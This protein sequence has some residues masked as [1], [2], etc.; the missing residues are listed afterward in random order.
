MKTFEAK[1]PAFQNQKILA[2]LKGDIERITEELKIDKN[3]KQNFI[4]FI[5]HNFPPIPNANGILKPKPM[6]NKL[7]EN[8]AL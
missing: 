3:D 1:D 2:D 4:D 7:G 8:K 5:Y 6:I